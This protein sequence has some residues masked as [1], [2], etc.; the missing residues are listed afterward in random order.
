MIRLA[1][2]WA[3][4]AFSSCVMY[5]QLSGSNIITTFAGTSWKFADSGSL[6]I[7]APLS[8]SNLAQLTTDA[9][10]NVIFADWGNQEV[11]RLNLNGTISTLAGNGIDGF[12]GDGGSA[13]SAALNRPSSAVMDASGNLYIYDSLNARIRKVNAQGIIT[14][15]AGTGISG[16]DGDNGPAAKAHI[17]STNAKLAVD[18]SGNLYLTSPNTGTIRRITPDGTISTYAGNG[19]P[20]SGDNVPATQAGLGLGSGQ[21]VCDAA[22]NLYIVESGANQIRIVST[23]GTISTIAGTGAVGAANGPAASATFNLP[24]GIALDPSG[25]IYIGDYNNGQVREISGGM[26][27]SIAGVKD[28]FGFSGDGGPP[29]K[30]EFELPTGVAFD[31]NGNIDIV[32][33]GNFR[34]RTVNPGTN[35][36]STIAGNGKFRDT[37]NGIPATSA[38]LFAPKQISFDPK[39]N[40]LI[41]DSNNYKLRRVNT[42]GTMDTLAGTGTSGAGGIPGPATKALLNFPRMAIADAKGVIYIADSGSSVVYQI[43]PLGNMTIFAGQGLFHGGYSGDGGPANKAMLNAPNALA[44]DAAG[45]VYISDVGDNCIRRVAAADLTISTYAGICTKGGFVDNVPPAQAKFLAPQAIAFDAQGNLLVAD[46]NNNRIRKVPPTGPV[47]T[48]AGTG[49]S[50]SNGNNGPANKAAIFSPIALAVDTSQA[51]SQGTIYF[52][53]GQEQYGG[54]KIRLITPS[55]TMQIFTGAGHLGFAGDGGAASQSSFGAAGLAL[56]AAGNLYV[57]DFYNDRIRVILA[58]PPTP[59]VGQPSLSFSAAAGGPQSAPQPIAFSSSLPGQLVAAQS[60]SPWLM[61]PS[62]VASAPQNIQVS[63]DP[64]KLAAGTYNG[65]VTL[66]SP[67]ASAAL[68]TIPVKLTVT[69]AVPPVLNLDA[70]DFTFSFLHGGAPQTKSFKVL[71]TGGGTLTFKTTISG[72]AAPGVSLSDVS[73][74]VLPD[75]PVVIVVTVDPTQLP[76]GSSSAQ[77]M[78]TGSVGSSESIPITI[79][80]TVAP[81]QSVMTLPER[82]FVFTGVQG[83]GV[84]PPQSLTV[85]N[86]GG[87]A[88]SYTAAPI[89]LT[90]SGWLN[91]SSGAGVSNPGSVGTASVSVNTAGLQPGVYYGLVRVSSPGTVNSPQDVEV[92]LNLFAPAFSPGAVVGP[93]GL[94]FAATT[95]DSDPGSQTFRITNLGTTPAPFVLRPVLIGGA[96]L[97]ARPNSGTIVAG[98][99]Q[100]ITLQANIGDLTPGVYNGSIAMQVGS[101][102]RA[103]NVLFVVAPEAISAVA[104]SDY[105]LRDSAAACSPTTLYPV[106]TS[107]VQD[108][109]VAAGWPVPVEVSVVDD[110][111][112]PM[113]TGRVVTSFSNGDPPVSLSSL[114]NGRWQGTWLGRNVKASQIVIAAA[115]N[116][117]A[118]QLAGTFNY[119]GTLQV[120]AG[121]PS[122]NAGGVSVGAVAAAQSPPA[123]GSVISISGTNLAPGNAAAQLPLSTALSGTEVLLGGELLP[124]LYT[125]SGLINAV[126]PYDLPVNAQYELIVSTGGMISGPQTVTVAAAQ[127]SIFTIDN[128][129]VASVAGAVWNQITNGTAAVAAAPSGG[130]SAGQKLV[131]YCT[132]LGAVNQ[133][134]D[135]T[136]GAPASVSASNTVSV[137]IGSQ[138][139]TPSFAGLVPG[140][141]GLYQ[142]NVT[143]PSGVAAGS[144]IPVSVS[145]AGQT[146]APVNVTMH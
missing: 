146:S 114:G 102:P 4:L 86:P 122:V 127:P 126:V 1:G 63:V 55:G 138:S 139:A 10:G 100:T 9:A 104:A 37:P 3:L 68:I 80:I 74:S 32:D 59:S 96:W 144:Q 124:L 65:N 69:A 99:S 87:A 47:T 58:T 84:T 41:A 67:G 53:E 137:S 36:I 135:P 72:A 105:H 131:I 142:V 14:T 19:H 30:A 34:I 33:S 85:L 62:N 13:R 88:F 6:A 12:S 40:M 7:N 83:S 44:L 46:A 82:G 97:Q 77:V 143:V 81:M 57:S 51:S 31:G 61:V 123:P 49:D 54:D 18:P 17:E 2:R 8:L 75:T 134:V 35:T 38:Y 125:S 22:G 42:N 140:Y 115:A 92:V 128:T 90:G 101:V 50:T 132:G 103:V 109:V 116:M 118:P 93:T 107:F 26:V 133:T 119:T 43:G 111:G 110:C 52:V 66:V 145:V 23:T 89:P 106:F 94:V 78:V 76:D 39:G 141:T 95:S 45:N 29:L 130:I 71:N 108:F 112:N 48:I 11:L 117:D 64:G 60:D 20:H 73:G 28:A 16:T 25:N 129:G 21:I 24:Q 120:N 113:K 5:A 27:T 56:D 121:V 79:T 70:P 15:I 136:T 91:V 98:G